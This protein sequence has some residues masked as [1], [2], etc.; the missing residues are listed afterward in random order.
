MAQLTIY[1][2]L[3]AD[4]AKKRSINVLSYPAVNRNFIMLE[5]RGH[6]EPVYMAMTDKFGQASHRVLFHK[7]LATTL[8]RQAGF[9]VPASIRT[10]SFEEAKQFLFDHKRIVVKPI[11]RSAGIGVT[12]DIT[13]EEELTAAIAHVRKHLLFR[14]GLFICQAHVEGNDY[15]VLVIGQKTIFSVQRV[16]AYVTGDGQRTVRQLMNDWNRG[17]I[18]M[19]RIRLGAAARAL[20]KRQ[21]VNVSS[22]PPAG[23]QVFL[24]QLANAHQGAIVHDM[25][26]VIAPEVRQMALG[27][28]KY[29]S[30]PYLGIDFI[31][32]D[33]TQTPGKI[34]ELNPNAGIALHH[35]PTVGSPRNVAGTIIEMLFSEL[36]RESPTSHAKEN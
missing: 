14:D 10:K 4:E 7:E 13:S 25:T 35:F 6:R 34:I 15:R 20:L 36:V 19:R 18:E 33:I 26:D 21:G 27:V 8:L 3:I 16:P 11:G 9:P 32:P 17:V 31:S 29:F 28:A 22:V 30:C 2:Q 12:V 23:T 5:Y 24:S 1:T